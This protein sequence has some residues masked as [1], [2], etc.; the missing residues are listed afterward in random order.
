[1]VITRIAPSPTGKFHIGTAR[2]ALFSYLFARQKGGKFFLRIEDTDQARSSDEHIADIKASLGWLGFKWDNKD[3]EHYQSKRIEEYCRVAQALITKGHAYEKEGAVYFKSKLQNPNVNSSSKSKIQINPKTQVPKAEI[4]DNRQPTTDDI[5]FT[6]LVH[7]AMSFDAKDIEDFVI[8]KSDGWPTFHLAVVVDDHDMGVTHVIRGDDHLSNTPKHILL[9]S[10]LGWDIPDYAHL[11]L[12]LNANRTKMSK[13]HDP[14]SV[15]DDFKKQGFLPEAMV[16]FLALL[17]WNPKTEEE[18]FTLDEL[19]KRF[20]IKGAQR[21]NAV[22]DSDRL[23]FFNAHY[24]RQ[25]SPQEIVMLARPLWEESYDI[26]GCGQTYLESVARLAVERSETVSDL[27]KDID[28]FFDEPKLDRAAIVFKK[29]TIEAT[30]KGL[31]GAI[32]LL[33]KLSKDEWAEVK[34]IAQALAR[35]VES[36]KLGNGDVFWPVRYALSGAIASPKPEELLAAL[37]KEKAI[38]RLDSALNLLKAQD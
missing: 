1:M 25:K 12:I 21:S 18:F 20:D 24:L 28:Y 30:Q 8:L 33:N 13:R 27:A 6:D 23:R 35:V 38:K 15:T 32:E 10:A 3:S 22:F 9:Y 37:G 29:S 31:A 11:P 14:V 19:I 7:G 16:N 34:I 2:T 17:G 5:A 26:S 36:E 4:P